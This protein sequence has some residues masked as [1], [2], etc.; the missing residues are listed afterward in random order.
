MNI[1]TDNMWMD[2]GEG[3]LHLPNGNAITTSVVERKDFG[4]VFE[5]YD[6][7]DTPE[8]NLRLI[9]AAPDLLLALRNLVE[10]IPLSSL[11]IRK[12]FGLINAHAHATKA[13]RKATG[14]A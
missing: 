2:C 5:V 3:T 8:E 11:N 4:R 13:I 9:L 7:S 1:T 12:D 10:Q 14:N 6:Y